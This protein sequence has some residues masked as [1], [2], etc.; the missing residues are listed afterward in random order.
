MGGGEGVYHLLMEVVS[1]TYLALVLGFLISTKLNG[2]FINIGEF[3]E[4]L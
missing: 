2:I 1:I 4:S 3:S